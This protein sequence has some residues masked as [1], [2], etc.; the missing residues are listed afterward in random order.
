MFEE[1]RTDKQSMSVQVSMP[2]WKQYEAELV[3]GEYPLDRY[4]GGGEESAVFLTRF[5]SGRAV[6]KLVCA[7]QAQ[8]VE[9]VE[10]W[11]LAAN[12]RHP[13][14]V[15]IFAAGTWEAPGMTLAYFVMEYAPE[16][17]ADVLRERPLTPDEAREMLEPVVDA[18]SYLHDQGLVHGDLK[19]A[20]IL[21]VDDQVKI[22]S[23]AIS[24]G[25]PAAD[26]QALGVSLVQV[27]TQQTATISPDSRDP[28]IETLPVPFREIAQSCLNHDP[29]LRWGASQILARLHSPA[30]PAD[31]LPAA[32]EAV[33]EL[34][35][36]KPRR[37]HYV[38]AAALVVVAAAVAVGLM[39]HRTAAPVPV[40]SP[41]AQPAP[42]PASP[43]PI[44]GAP[45]NT[46]KA[47]PQAEAEREAEP[48]R[49]SPSSQDGIVRRVL[50]EIPTKAR[51]TVHGK[52]T[53]VVRVAVDAS[54]K[55]TQAMLEHGGSA[56]F[57][58]LALEAARQWQFVPTERPGTRNWILR[59]EILR[60]E[61]RVTPARAR[62]E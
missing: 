20:N 13:H 1:I 39:M 42:A 29:R 36:E 21:A 52:A 17:L 57:G 18:L 25:D 47:A 15:R 28:A 27:L 59:F 35:S 41:P 62:G 49:G 7:D 2:A 33:T 22:S 8:A 54:G 51:D 44:P 38:A 60:M 24:A 30:A 26:I 6:I 12:L 61:T 40:T 14:L 10:R 58:R 46:P 3:H 43:A 11:N 56:Y 19:P 45:A 34:V 4:L 37:R 55:V 50:P 9:L 31:N 48:M 5:D 53:V 32:A 23:E 16:N